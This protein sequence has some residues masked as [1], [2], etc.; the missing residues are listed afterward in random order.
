[1]RFSVYACVNI[2]LQLSVGLFVPQ[3]ESQFGAEAPEVHV[4]QH[5]G[6]LCCDLVHRLRE[7]SKLH[8]HK[9]SA[10]GKCY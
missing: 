2:Y 4:T 5:I 6:P 9:E 8:S 1:M 7:Q 10:F 3:H